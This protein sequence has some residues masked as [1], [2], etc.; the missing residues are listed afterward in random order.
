MGAAHMRKQ[1][2]LVCGGAGVFIGAVVVRACDIYE[3]AVETGASLQ[4]VCIMS[5]QSLE[6]QYAVVNQAHGTIVTRAAY[7]LTCSKAFPSA[8]DDWLIASR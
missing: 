6:R 8:S 4:E 1:A 5:H 3:I 7:Y 2:L